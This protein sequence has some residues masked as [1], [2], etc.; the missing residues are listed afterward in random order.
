[1]KK[2]KIDANNKNYIVADTGTEFSSVADTG[3]DLTTF[4]EFIFLLLVF[5]ML[6]PFVMICSLTF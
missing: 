1:V 4:T 2:R 5:Q 3:V 6:M